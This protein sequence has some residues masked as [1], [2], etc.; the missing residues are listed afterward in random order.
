MKAIKLSK[1]QNNNL[2]FVKIFVTSLVL[3]ML[4][5][6]YSVF[7]EHPTLLEVEDNPQCTKKIE[8]TN[9]SRG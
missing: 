8:K 4:L 1:T 7:A 2:S 3:V 9:D 6:L 5:Q